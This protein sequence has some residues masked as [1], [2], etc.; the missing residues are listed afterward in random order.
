MEWSERMNAAIAYIE[1]NL[2][3]ESDSPLLFKQCYIPGYHAG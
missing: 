1:E 3:S 2:D